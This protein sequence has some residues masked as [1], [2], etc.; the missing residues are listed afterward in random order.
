MPVASKPAI[1]VL[2]PPNHSTVMTGTHIA[3]QVSVKDA[4]GIE[5]IQVWDNARLIVTDR[6]VASTEVYRPYFWVPEQIGLHTIKIVA[7]NRQ[8]R[9]SESQPIVL[10]VT[11]SN[12]LP[13]TIA[14]ARGGTATA[15]PSPLPTPAPLPVPTS[16]PT[17]YPTP[18]LLPMPTLVPVPTATALP[19]FITTPGPDVGIPVVPMAECTNEAQVAEDLGIPDNSQL[20]PGVTFAKT[21]RLR[22][23]G[24][25]TWDTHYQLIFLRGSQLGGQSPVF[26]NQV[27]PPGATVDVSV[28]MTAPAANGIYYGEWQLRDPAGLRFGTILHVLIA[29]RGL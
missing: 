16:T 21:W 13:M 17:L 27:T 28:L 23:T 8:G 20:K 2:A 25:C 24:T 10:Y 19:V 5:W 15:T 18:T 4:T 29:V 14:A 12:Y 6:P 22:N 11:D 3:I 1:H 26:L 7:A 9:S